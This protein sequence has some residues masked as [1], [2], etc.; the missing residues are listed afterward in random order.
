M[1]PNLRGSYQVLDA[2]VTVAPD[3]KVN[4]S[5]K[6]QDSKGSTDEKI[7]AEI[8]KMIVLADAHPE[9]KRSN[10]VLAGPGCTPRL[11][12]FYKG[13]IVNLIHRAGEVTIIDLESFISLCNRRRL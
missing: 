6:W 10:I 2:L 8:L 1:C 7:P 9:I 5:L 11:K 3:E 13:E 4:V 12:E